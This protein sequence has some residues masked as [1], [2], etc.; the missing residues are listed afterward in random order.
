MEE[1]FYL[2]EKSKGGG[3]EKGVTVEA[4]L[5]NLERSRPV[6]SPFLPLFLCPR[7]LATGRTPA[8]DLEKILRGRKG[9][10]TTGWA[11]S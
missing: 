10:R 9:E 2:E 11:H 7:F 5:Q 4:T 3:R 6:P 1:K 8:G